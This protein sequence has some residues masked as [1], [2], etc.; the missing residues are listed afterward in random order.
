MSH[1]STMM[2]GEES[3]PA[4][5]WLSVGREAKRRGI[6]GVVMMGAHWE[7]LGDKIQVAMKPNPGKSPVAYV[8]P[9]WYETYKI[10]ASLELGQRC[11]G[12]LQKACY[13]VEANENF[14]YIHD[15]FLV[16]IRM[17]PDGCPPTTIVSMNARFDPHFHMKMGSTLRPLRHQNILL[18]GSG[19]AVH[20]LYRN[21]WS[22]MML[23][24]DPFAQ[25]VPP[26][27]WAL[28]FRQTFEDAMTGN[29]GPKLRR[30]M[31][32]LMK[33]PLYRDAHATGTS[34]D[35]IQANLVDDHFMSAL[36][37]AGAA[38]DKEDEGTKNT[39]TAECWELVNMCNTQF[40]L[41]EW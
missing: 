38:G 29:S 40:Q 8:D 26:E 24:R 15:T 9:K 7:C 1:G 4:D 31:T 22:H 41:G 2:L 37:V 32:R 27:P 21:H 34:S 20:N 23:Y 14:D 35:S 33:H 6:E 11:M 19:G 13:E 5:F 16:L 28:E 10:N 30:A 17:F 25:H 3:A 18:I 39:M 36:F 12:L